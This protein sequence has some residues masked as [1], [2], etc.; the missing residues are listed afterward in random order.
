MC[1]SHK[2][3]INKPQIKWKMFYGFDLF[4]RSPFT[5]HPFSGKYLF[6][7][8]VLW[9][10]RVKRE[11]TRLSQT[12]HA[13][14]ECV[15]MP[16]LVYYLPAIR[17]TAMHIWWCRI[18]SPRTP[19]KKGRRQMSKSSVNARATGHRI[20]PSLPY[21]YEQSKLNTQ[22]L[23]HIRC[24][25][26]V[27]NAMLSTIDARTCAT[28]SIWNKQHKGDSDYCVSQYNPL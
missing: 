8:S 16:R 5:A 23:T 18:H 21:L 24:T 25:Q 27:Q 19:G 13:D 15:W 26:N 6:L 11:I 22:L 28:Y 2:N 3:K 4:S 20:H 7:Y 12:H 17:S 10:V 1:I 9:R 14:T